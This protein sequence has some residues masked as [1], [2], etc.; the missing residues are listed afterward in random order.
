MMQGRGGPAADVGQGLE[1]GYLSPAAVSETVRQGLQGLAVDGR[2]VLVLIPDGTRTMPVPFMFD[3]LDVELTPRVAALD[4]LVALGTHQPLDDS[5]LGTLIGRPVVGGRAGIHRIYNHRWDDPTAFAHLGTIAADDISGLTGFPAAADVPVALNR[6]AVEYDHVLIC[7]PVFPHEVAGFSG[8]AK[9][10]FPGIAAPDIIHFTHWL[11]ALITCFEV[12]GTRDTPVR[13]V[14]NR[15]AA[16]LP[17]P[18]SLIALVVTHEGTA[19][20]YCGE[21]HETWRRA[22]ALSAARHIVWL[23]QPVDRVLA[24]MPPMYTDLWTAA[25]GFYK[26]EPVV[27]DGGEVVIYAPHVHEVSYVHGHLLDEVGYHCRDY[28]LADWKRFQQYPGGILAHSTHVT[29]VG[30]FDA[31]SG[32][33]ILRI[34][35]S[36]ATGISRERCERINLGYVDPATIDPDV[37]A[38]DPRTLVVP[39][40]G[41]QL[42]RLGSPPRIVEELHGR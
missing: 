34:R 41:E 22:V 42:Y 3:L 39:R 29:G 35:V 23:D 11:G 17:T 18:V 31:A 24:I 1:S 27:A 28:F 26:T 36:L 2:R 32:R 33:E 7:G 40:A 19:G 30:T 13:A 4:F 20:V 15:A 12:I 16:L 10:L 9:Y 8:G 6:L 21:L 37:W 14:I 5:Q 38:A 25:K